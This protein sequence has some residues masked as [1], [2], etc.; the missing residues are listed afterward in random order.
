LTK[1]I[2]DSYSE[3]KGFGYI[4]K[5]DGKSVLFERNSIEG[6]GYKNVTP[7]DRVTFDV[8]KSIQGPVAKKVKKS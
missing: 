1:G 5:E 2:V 8:E 7:G 3:D 4:I 6:S